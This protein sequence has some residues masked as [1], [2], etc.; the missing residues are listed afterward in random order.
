MKLYMQAFEAGGPFKKKPGPA[1][2]RPGLADL[3]GGF[4]MR[5]GPAYRLFRLF[6]LLRAGRR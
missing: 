1:L 4:F 2:Q 6:R 5:A 3:S